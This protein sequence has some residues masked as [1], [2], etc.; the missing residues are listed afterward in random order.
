METLSPDMD[1]LPAQPTEQEIVMLCGLPGSGKTTYT[2]NLM[3]KRDYLKLSI[4]EAVYER[5][6]RYNVDYHHLEYRRLETETYEELDKELVRTLACGRSAILDYG[7]WL[8]EQRDKYKD[9]ART[10]GVQSRLLYFKADRDVL[11][12]RLQLRNQRADP[13]ALY[14]DEDLFERMH[15]RFEEPQDEKEI[16]LIQNNNSRM[17]SSASHE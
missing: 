13:N 7:F 15:L 10:M 2:T 11:W 16:I 8:K 12:E 14:V 9:I 6:G 4:D 1:R 17:P 5:H 3:E